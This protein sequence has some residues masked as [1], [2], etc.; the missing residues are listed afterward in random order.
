MGEAVRTPPFPPAPWPSWTE[1]HWT[2]MTIARRAAWY[3]LRDAAYFKAWN[4]WRKGNG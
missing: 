2:E 3:E 1:Q 4:K